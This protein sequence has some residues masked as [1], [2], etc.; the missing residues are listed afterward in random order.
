VKG[1][2]LKMS[3]ARDRIDEANAGRCTNT[4]AMR[5]LGALRD[6]SEPAVAINRRPDLATTMLLADRP[7]KC[8]TTGQTGDRDAGRSPRPPA[9]RKEADCSTPDHTFRS[10]PTEDSEPPGT[11][12]QQQ[13]VHHLA[14]C[15]GDTMRMH[16]TRHADLRGTE[17]LISSMPGTMSE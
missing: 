11:G 5:P 9:Q 8:L 1:G 15:T 13:R 2:K 12:N 17:P 14:T 6:L 16:G 7:V 10:R 3:G 4:T